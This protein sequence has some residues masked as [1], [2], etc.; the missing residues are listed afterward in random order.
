MIHKILLVDDEKAILK[1]LH[2]LLRT[3]NIDIYTSSSPHDALILCQEHE[4]TLILSDQRMPHMDG[5][6]LLQKIKLLQPDSTRVILSAYSD[7]D[8]ITDAF[9][10]NIIHKFI[11]KP[12]NNEELTFVVKSVT[13][14]DKSAIEENTVSN[15]NLISFHGIYTQCD[16]MLNL[17]DMI[18]RVAT[19]NVPV[20]IY[21]ATGTGKELVAQAL[22]KE[23]NRRDEKF[24]AINCANLTSELAESQLFGHKKGAFTGASH[25][26]EG[27]LTAANGGTLFLDEVTC[28][29]IPVQVKLLRALQEREYYKVGSTETVP[30]DVQV[31]SASSTSMKDAVEDGGFR[32]DLRFRLEVIPLI[33]PALNARGIDALEIFK[34]FMQQ[35]RP[36]SEIIICNEAEQCI[37]SYAWPGNVRELFNAAAYAHAMAENNIGIDHLPIDLKNGNQKIDKN[38]DVN[39]LL[40]NEN[41]TLNIENI[42]RALKIHRGNR[43]KTAES[44]N[45]SRMT[46]W[47]KMKQLNL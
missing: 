22:H 14:A 38:K 12:W 27:L 1:S 24:L 2:R 44:L 8:S 46:L 36:K 31:I 45:V 10:N 20:S 29:T 17:F 23:G 32:P 21:G 41:S 13:E 28:L 30:F 5:T 33:L 18:K 11:S 47:R 26:S 43:S 37:L 6:E 19:A 35:Y 16:E 34:I 42:T 40:V 4:F 25:D 9:N 39:S 3:L 15:S 7:F